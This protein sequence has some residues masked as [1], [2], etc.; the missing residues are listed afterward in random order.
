MFIAVVS[1]F[2]CYPL[3][4]CLNPQWSVDYRSYQYALTLLRRGGDSL[5]VEIAQMSSVQF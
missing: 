2:V 5:E 3:T 1:F 4:V